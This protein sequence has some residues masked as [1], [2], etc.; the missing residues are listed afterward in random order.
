M[1]IDFGVAI[2]G[3]II[4]SAFTVC[5]DERF[6][7]LL[8]ASKDATNSA[9]KISGPDA[10]MGEIASV[11]EEVI[12]SYQLEIDGKIFPLKPIANLGG[13]GL[14]K[15]KVHCGNRIPNV[16]VNNGFGDLNA[17]MEVGDYYALE[18]FAT[19]GI[20]KVDRKGLSSHFMLNPQAPKVKGGSLRELEDIIQKNFNTMAFCQRFLEKVGQRNYKRSLEKLVQM[21]VVNPYPPLLDSPGSYVSQYEHS[22]GIFEDGIEVF[23]RDVEC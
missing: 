8:D 18:T 1:K 5:F 17:K 23:S 20:G 2:E 10:R 9:I 4:D 14:G 12:K 3:N 21:K 15:Y 11:I 13:H 16:N 19:T 6:K 22:F 7:P